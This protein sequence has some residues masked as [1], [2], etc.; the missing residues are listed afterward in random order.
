MTDIRRVPILISSEGA[1]EQLRGPCSST[2]LP[3]RIPGIDFDE[4]D[5][6]P[7]AGREEGKYFTV[8]KRHEDGS[9]EGVR[10]SSSLSTYF[11]LPLPSLPEGPRVNR[12]EP[13]FCSFLSFS[14]PHP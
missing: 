14:A 10:G 2:L 1:V 3:V 9:A 13:H 6:N 12:F 4:P 7:A 11:C 5:R 8:T